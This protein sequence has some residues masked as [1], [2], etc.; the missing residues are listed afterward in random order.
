MANVQEKNKGGNQGQ[1]ESLLKSV[2]VDLKAL[3]IPDFF[4]ERLK[5][6]EELKQKER[7]EN[8]KKGTTVLRFC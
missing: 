1:K 8:A 5:V 4:E 3:P 2:N 7:E 6:W